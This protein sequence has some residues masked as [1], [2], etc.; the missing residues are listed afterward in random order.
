MHAG[1]RPQ[2]P[3]CYFGASPRGLS[4][5]HVSN[6]M[7]PQASTSSTSRTWPGSVCTGPSRHASLSHIPLS[8]T[9]TASNQ[10]NIRKSSSHNTPHCCGLPHSV[11]CYA[12]QQR[13]LTRHPARHKLIMTRCLLA[14][15]RLY[16]ISPPH[17]AHTDRNIHHIQHF[18]TM[19]L[20][21]LITPRPDDGSESRVHRYSTLQSYTVI[22]ACC[23][24]SAAS[25][26]S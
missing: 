2:S 13:P 20:A 14:I 11:L 24:M 26:S 19:P 18:T 25:S 3:R 9:S 7:R 17:P 10:P 23:A 21:P 8:S 5:R 15:D 12:C 6:P 22:N 4:P 1:R 16:Q